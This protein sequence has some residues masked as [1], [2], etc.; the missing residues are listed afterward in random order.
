M[1][2]SSE[3]RANNRNIPDTVPDG[4]GWVMGSVSAV[5]ITQFDPPYFEVIGEH[6]QLSYLRGV[7]GGGIFRVPHA[8][9]LGVSFHLSN[10]GAPGGL[11]SREEG[12]GQ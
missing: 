6:L 3:A 12:R 7:H 2:R 1:Q 8:L 5:I 4:C 11:I 9:P 10:A